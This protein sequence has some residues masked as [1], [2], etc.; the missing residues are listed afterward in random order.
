LRFVYL[1]QDYVQTDQITVEI[2]GEQKNGFQM[3]GEY[4]EY[5]TN[6]FEIRMIKGG[7]QVLC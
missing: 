3:D 6:K 2:V 4:Y 5:D 1:K 7:L